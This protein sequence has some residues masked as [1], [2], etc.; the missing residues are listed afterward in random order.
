MGFYD[1]RLAKKKENVG[2]HPAWIGI[3]C[4]MLVVVPIVSFAASDLLIESN[5]AT[6]AIPSA[7]RG[8]LTIPEVGYIRYFYAKAVVTII[9]SVATFALLYMIYALMYR[10]TGQTN[11]GPMDAAPNR[12]KVKKRN[13]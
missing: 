11:R 6:I 8:G 13:R 12:T 5:L 4:I 7:L 10:I 3:G 2:I 9:I 1:K